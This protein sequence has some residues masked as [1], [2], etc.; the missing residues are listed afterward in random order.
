MAASD[1]AGSDVPLEKASRAECSREGGSEVGIEPAENRTAGESLR[2]DRMTT[3]EPA[4]RSSA[5]GLSYRAAS[6]WP[7]VS[8]STAALRFRPCISFGQSS[9]SSVFS[10]PPRPTT[11]GTERATSR[12]P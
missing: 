8:W 4:T 12:S 3:P 9:I 11:V 7:S 10:A 5:P 2:Q 6:T 1:G